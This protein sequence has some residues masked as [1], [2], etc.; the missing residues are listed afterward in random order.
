MMQHYS[1]PPQLGESFS[2]HVD[3]MARLSNAQGAGLACDSVWNSTEP[4][5]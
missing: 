3:I 1:H 2:D 5:I 4:K